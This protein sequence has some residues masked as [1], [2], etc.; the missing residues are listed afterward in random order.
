MQALLGELRPLRTAGAEVAALREQLSAATATAAS[1]AA[2]RDQAV[3]A[4][5]SAAIALAAAQDKACRLDTLNAVME[6]LSS[7]VQNI[8]A[9]G[10]RSGGDGSGA[11]A[12]DDEGTTGR[13]SSDASS[14]SAVASL[15]QLLATLEERSRDAIGLGP[16]L[17]AAETAAEQHRRHIER[18][19]TDV[20]RTRVA[21]ANAK[22]RARVER[23]MGVQLQAE[24]ERVMRL[25]EAAG[26]DVGG[27]AGWSSLLQRLEQQPM[28]LE[29]EEGAAF[30]AESTAEST[31][32]HLKL[33]VEALQQLL[34]AR[35]ESL[36][37][38][39]EREEQMLSSEWP[40][41]WWS[42]RLLNPSANT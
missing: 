22:E 7:A 36:Q 32:G 41:G 17:A 13:T 6:L 25:A 11:T 21:A 5:D 31:A 34:A 30:T 24:L 14:A 12:E 15:H 20:E 8:G 2:A 27:D 33:E 23:L 28:T 26:V 3:K 18:L 9:G 39:R 37:A 4:A 38:M 19:V 29:P 10:S 16:R 42:T 35:D 40:L 1:L